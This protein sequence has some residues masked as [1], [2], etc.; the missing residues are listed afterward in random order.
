[1]KILII[2]DSQEMRES[3]GLILN[4]KKTDFVTAGSADEGIKLFDAD[5]RITHVLT[6]R[7]NPEE[8]GGLKVLKHVR[9]SGRQVAAALM[10]G[11]TIE[12]GGEVRLDAAL[13]K[14]FKV[15][16][17]EAFLRLSPT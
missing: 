6:D 9:G 12:V 2:D 16:V 14:P 4:L 1:M 13:L 8:D 3:I 5:T 7:D 15:E 10:S 17:L 11:R